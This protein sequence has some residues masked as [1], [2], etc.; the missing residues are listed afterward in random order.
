MRIPPLYR[1]PSWQRFLGGMAIGAFV[2][3]FFFLY[4][5]GEWQ[6]DY[7][8]QIDGQKDLIQEL[9]KE[10]DIWQ[11]EFKKLNKENKEKLTVQ[12]IHLKIDNYNKYKLDVYSVFEAEKT[13]KEEISMMVAKDIETV[14]SSLGL[15]ERIIQNKTLEINGKRYKVTIKKM[16]VYTTF[17]IHVNLQLE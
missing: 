6:E 14:H 10:K 12:Q 7:S 3:W 9:T 4:I 17:S 5:F 2:S 16:S 15:I 11:E 13:L 1:K 8:K